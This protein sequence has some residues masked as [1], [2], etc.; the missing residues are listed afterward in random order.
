MGKYKGI[1]KKIMKDKS[2]HIMVRFKHNGITY[3]IKNFSKLFGSQSEKDAFEKLNEVKSLLSKGIDPFAKTLNSLNELYEEMAESF[4]KSK[5]WNEGTLKT[6]SNFYNKYIRKS[7]GQ[8]RLEKISYE[9]LIKI[10]NQFTIDQ[11]TMKKRFVSILKPI[12]YDQKKKGKIYKNIM[13]EIDA[14]SGESIKEVLHNRINTDYN[15]VLRRFYFAIK[16]YREPKPHNQERFQMYL[17]MLVLTAHRVGELSKLKKEHCDLENRKIIAPTSIT[18]SNRDY[19]F[20]IPDEVYDYIKNHP[21]GLLFGLPQ[22]SRSSAS[23]LFKLF[24]KFIGI[25][26]IEGHNFTSHDMR[27]LM[28]TTM[29]TKLG[30]DSDLADY[31]LEHSQK[32]VKKHYFNFTYKD[33]EN[34]YFTYWDY[35]RGLSSDLE[36]EPMSG[37][38]HLVDTFNRTQNDNIIEQSKQETTKTESKLEKLERLSSLYEKELITQEEFIKLKNELI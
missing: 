28:A 2:V 18:K 25:S 9:D 33:K 22:T 6:N 29:V 11:I 4:T 20:P 19:H 38:E 1:S 3:P 13:D 26:V 17:Y 35:L 14:I 37:Q 5:Q 16:Y 15:E 8:K 7:L 30:I 10:L 31:C 12:F 24:T 32:G 27:K 21:G 34:A 36:Y 23:R